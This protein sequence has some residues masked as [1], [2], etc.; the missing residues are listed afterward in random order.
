MRSFAS[1][2][3]TFTLHYIVENVM[4]VNGREIP[5]KALKKV[6]FAVSS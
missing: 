4:S 5:A 6:V 1:K 2:E 3:V